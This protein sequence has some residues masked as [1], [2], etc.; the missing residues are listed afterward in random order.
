MTGLGQVARGEHG[1]VRHSKSFALAARLLSPRDRE[2]VVLLYAWCRRADDAIDRGRPEDQPRA[3]GQLRAELSRVYAGVPQEDPVLDGFARVV[4]QFRVPREVPEALLDGMEM[5]VRGDRY[6]TW[7]DLLGYCY[8]VASTVGLMLCH[9]LGATD[10]RARRHAVHL[11]LAMQLTNIARDVSED[12]NRGRLYLPRSLF[13]NH[14]I[15]ESVTPETFPT[16][17]REGCRA[18]LAELLGVADRYYA[19]AD[20]GLRYLPLRAAIAVSVARAVYA[21][22]GRVVAG[23]GYDVLAPRAV[24]PLW[25]K[26]LLAVGAV[27][28]ALVRRP[29]LPHARDRSSALPAPGAAHVHDL[30]RL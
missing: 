9:V 15:P 21:H 25:R 26:L 3:L 10:P 18:V 12:C 2:P 17:A 1:I 4:R 8:R 23:S 11:G 20:A 24:V 22:I 7:E 6:A 27:G 14:G 5:D 29:W 16:V 13:A 30:V 19:S 28:R